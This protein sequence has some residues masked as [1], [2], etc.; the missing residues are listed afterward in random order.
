MEVIQRGDWKP[1]ADEGIIRDVFGG[2]EE[3]P[4]NPQFYNLESMV[5][6]NVR[7]PSRSIGDF[8]GEV[9]EGKSLGLD[10]RRSVFIGDLGVDRPIA[11]DYRFSGSEPRVL[12]LCTEGWVKIATNIQEFIL[13]C[14]M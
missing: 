7:L 8:F 12:F 10:P 13:K 5:P 1:P 11:L 4:E 9:V 2:E 6:Q 3:E 14:E